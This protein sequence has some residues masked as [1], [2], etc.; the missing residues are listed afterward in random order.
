MANTIFL[1]VGAGGF[2]AKTSDCM[3]AGCQRMS[4]DFN[5]ELTYSSF[6]SVDPLGALL[7]LVHSKS[8][9]KMTVLRSVGWSLGPRI[10][11]NP[12]SMFKGTNPIRLAST[13]SW[14]REVLFQI[15][16]CS[17]HIVGIC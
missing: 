17:M 9:L 4:E 1:F 2:V 6:G 13:S 8:I 12:G 10:S 16:T 5:S 11:I 3:P 14:M 15:K 7:F